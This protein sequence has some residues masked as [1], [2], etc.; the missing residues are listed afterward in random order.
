MLIRE[1]NDK[2]MLTLPLS[3][4]VFADKY[5]SLQLAISQISVVDELLAG[6]YTI[7]YVICTY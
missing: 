6:T 4:K 3:S 2:I 7:M 5:D 1:N